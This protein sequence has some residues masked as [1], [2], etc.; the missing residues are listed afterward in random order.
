MDDNIFTY[1]KNNEY[2]AMLVKLLGITITEKT[3]KINMVKC[4]II[5]AENDTST[6]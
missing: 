3:I 1:N 5:V 4:K 6:K 2:V